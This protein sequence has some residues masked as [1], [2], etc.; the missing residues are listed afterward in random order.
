[1]WFERSGKLFLVECLLVPYNGYYCLVYEPFSIQLR[2]INQN[3]YTCVGLKIKQHFSNFL[4]NIQA[5][6][7]TV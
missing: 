7:F 1:V 6:I 3:T 2:C 5:Y 4:C